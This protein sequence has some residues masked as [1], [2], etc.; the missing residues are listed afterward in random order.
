MMGEYKLNLAYLLARRKRG[1][2]LA[3]HTS[4]SHDETPQNY[5]W[6]LQKIVDIEDL[7]RRVLAEHAVGEC[8]EI[9]VLVGTFFLKP[10]EEDVSELLVV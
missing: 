9:V 4:A 7:L 1:G 8:F 2:I 3:Q 10:L 6:N 5:H